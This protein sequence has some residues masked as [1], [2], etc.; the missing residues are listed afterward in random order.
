MRGSLLSCPLFR[1]TPPRRRRDTLLETRPRKGPKL[2]M[3][4]CLHQLPRPRAPTQPATVP[5]Q[6]QRTRKSLLTQLLLVAAAPL[7]QTMA[8][9][10][11]RTRRHR[12]TVTN[13]L[14]A[15]RAHFGHL[16]SLGLLGE[17]VGRLMMILMAAVGAAV[18]VEV[19]AAVAVL[20]GRSLVTHTGSENM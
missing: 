20:A 4:R 6:A 1:Q 7:D 8:R 5:P 11:L 14:P 10:G 9:A 19:A 12:R 3:L 13:V 15:L 17:A 16:E 18:V 2:K